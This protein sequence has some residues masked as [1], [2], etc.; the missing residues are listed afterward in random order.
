MRYNE[1]FTRYGGPSTEAEV[2]IRDYLIR[3]DKLDTTQRIKDYDKSAADTIQ[4]CREL[5]EDLGQY[6]QALAHRYAEL[7]TM[8]YK[9][10]LEIERQKRY[11]NK[12]KYYI[13]LV[14]SYEDGSEITVLNE[15][16]QGTE[17]SQAL[18]RFE[19][20]KKSRP[21]IDAVK[22]IE[23]GYWEK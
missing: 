12:V 23:K 6:R 7:E 4:R 19:E 13:R 5:I 11:D 10:R 16:Y 14:K 3:P 21:G 22:N 1:M 20:L 15:V 17:R 8:S 9:L 18:K 2:C